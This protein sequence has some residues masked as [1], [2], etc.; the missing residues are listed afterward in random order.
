MK[1]TISM[2]NYYSTID[3]IVMT[4]SDI[5]NVNDFDSIIVLFERANKNGFD[6]AEGRLPNNMF[7]K[8]CGFSEDELMELENYLLRNAFLIW[9]MAREANGVKNA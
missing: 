8:T 3:N 9:E 1:G 2:K 4:Y 5:E 7:H 6:F